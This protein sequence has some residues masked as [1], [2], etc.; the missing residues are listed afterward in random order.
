MWGPPPGFLP[1]AD[2]PRSPTGLFDFRGVVHCHS[3]RSHDSTGTIAEIGAAC[4]SVGM[5]YLVM[6]DHQTPHSVSRGRRGMVGDTLFL[7][8][9][10]LRV[11]GGSLLAF[12][13]KHY[14]RPAKTLQIYLY[15]IHGQGGLAF[16]DHA[17]RFTAWDHKGLDGVEI[18]NL[19]AAARAANKF[20]LV[21]KTL[22]MPLSVTFASLIVPNAEVFGNWDRRNRSPRSGGMLPIVGGND[23]HAN[24]RLLGSAGWV[25]GNYEEVFRVLSTHVLARSLDEGSLVEGFRAGRT[26]VVMD[27]LRDGSGFAFWAEDAGRRHEMGATVST[28]AVLR[29]R[30]PK[31]AQIRLLRDGAVVAK[32]EGSELTHPH[33]LAGVYRVEV[34]LFDTPWIFS[35]GIAVTGN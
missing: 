29:V 7:V 5:D 12:P 6:T 25:I 26:Y 34:R 21:V 1:L 20:E 15:D 13:L 24:I 23:A 33:P 16:I 22:L 9:A 32:V 35:S 3:F 4:A 30:T 8:G 11:P 10:E 14:V 18:H 2:R 28:G 27:L 31:T 17:E 19:H